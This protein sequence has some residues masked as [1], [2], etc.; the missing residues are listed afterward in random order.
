MCPSGAPA[1]CPQ[2]VQRLNA[3]LVT[4]LNARV[5]GTAT[6]TN[7]TF[8][9]AGQPFGGPSVSFALHRDTYTATVS[10]REKGSEG[11][12]AYNLDVDIGPYDRPPD[13]ERCQVQTDKGMVRIDCGHTTEPDGNVLVRAVTASPYGSGGYATLLLPHALVELHRPS[14]EVTRVMYLAV[15]GR[16]PRTPGTTPTVLPM[17]LSVDQLA[18]IARGLAVHPR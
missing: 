16:E 13:Q 17:K 1:D 5:P 18:D 7:N 9:E 3:A 12:T 14:G 8:T 11:E 2:V 4:L 15:V 6:V 10:V